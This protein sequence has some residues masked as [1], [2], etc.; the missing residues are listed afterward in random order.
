MHRWKKDWEKQIDLRD[1]IATN[2]ILSKMMF[3]CVQR[4]FAEPPSARMRALPADV[5]QVIFDVA[6]HA[7]Q[8]FHCLR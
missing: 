5:A 8:T 3:G 2:T 6:R 7:M 1:A 4:L